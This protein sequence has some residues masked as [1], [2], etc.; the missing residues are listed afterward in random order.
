MGSDESHFNVSVGSDGQSHK[1][2]STNHN[3]LKRKE[4]RSGIEPRSFRFSQ[5][6][7]NDKVRF[8]LWQALFTHALPLGQTGSQRKLIGKRWWFSRLL[9]CGNQRYCDA[10]MMVWNSG[11]EYGAKYESMAAVVNKTTGPRRIDQWRQTIVT[12][13]SRL[14]H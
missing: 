8:P 4:N 14:F 6:G 7:I 2:V 1:T 3:F 5:T 9:G 11:L 13:K 12:R 10:T